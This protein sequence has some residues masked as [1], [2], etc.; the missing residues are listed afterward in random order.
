HLLL[1]FYAGDDT[2]PQAF[3]HKVTT[4][5]R[6]APDALAELLRQAGLTEVTRLV[7]EPYEGERFQQAQLLVRKA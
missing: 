2:W 1:G 3:D 4:A 5:Y 7:R 6:W